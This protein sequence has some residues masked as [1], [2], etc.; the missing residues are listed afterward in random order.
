MGPIMKRLL[1]WLIVL[2]VL[3]GGGMAAAGP[4]MSYLQTRAM[5]K[6]LT[7]QVTRGQVQTV[8]NSTGTVK[9]VRT[10]SVG[11]FTS[12]PVESVFVDYNSEIKEGQLLARID[13]KLQQAAV[14]HD[15]ALLDTQKA[16]LK[17]VEAL[18]KQAENNEQRAHQLAGLN[19]D[20]IS[21]T[22]MDQYVYSTLT[23]VAQ[24]Q[25]A[26]ANI[27]SAEAQLKNS[28]AQLGY[29]KIVSPVNGVVIE[30][31]IDPGQTVAAGFQTPELFVVA[32]EMEKHMYVYASVDEADVGLIR[33]AQ[34]HDATV[35][36]TVDAYPT[37]VFEGKIYQIR[38]N[39]T[40]T[41]NVVTYP[42]IID[43]PNH[44]RKLTNLMTANLTFPI[45]A[46]PN[47]LRLPSGA[48]RFTP[49]PAQVR[50]ED[51][52]F[53]DADLPVVSTESAQKRSASEKAEQSRSRQHR[54][55]WVQ[56]GMLLR[57]VPVTLGLIEHQWAEIVSG[58]LTE[59]QAVVTGTEGL[60]SGR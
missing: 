48:L 36:F 12:G 25:L 29:T 14:D 51:R 53:V 23:Y 57:A 35:T 54:I 59:G 26:E 3:A 4:L 1:K 5:P 41:Q 39:A 37:D 38:Q 19:K 58:D 30:R 34:Q 24:K 31:K 7:A 22:E 8:V 27:K 17:R 15:Q 16:E 47:V 43:A 32:P 56:D 46:K 45:E 6:Y 18:L 13:P 21:A 28:Q 11:S 9:P 52:H 44:E 40:T 60:L 50:P 42:V 20:Y 55:V 10:V 49:L 2:A 33:Q